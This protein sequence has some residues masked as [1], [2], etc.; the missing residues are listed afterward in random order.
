MI[1]AIPSVPA[2]GPREEYLTIYYGSQEAAYSELANGNIDIVLAPLDPMQAE[3]AF[4]N[5]DP[6]VAAGHYGHSW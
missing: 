6:V 3:N 4:A 2:Y 5:P 1:A